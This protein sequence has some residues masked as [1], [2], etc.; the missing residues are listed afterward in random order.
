MK[1]FIKNLQINNADQLTSS[2]KKVLS[3][4]VKVT[5]VSVVFVEIENQPKLQ[6]ILIYY[7]LIVSSPH[8]IQ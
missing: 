3:K 8:F 7:S 6:K 5:N 1:S 2:C 4:F